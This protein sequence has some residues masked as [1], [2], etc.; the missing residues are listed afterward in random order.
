MTL[1]RRGLKA[2]VKYVP[3]DVVRMMLAGQMSSDTNVMARH[4]VTVMFMDIEGFSTLCEQ[5]QPDLLMRMTHDYLHEM[6]EVIVR[7]KGT[8]DKAC[9]TASFPRSMASGL[10]HPFCAKRRCLCQSGAPKL[11]VPEIGRDGRSPQF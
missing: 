10:E 4:V 11:A 8:L 6:C 7:S 9:D 2:F 1:S 3:R 5:I